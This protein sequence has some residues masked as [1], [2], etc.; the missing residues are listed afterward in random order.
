MTRAEIK[1]HVRQSLEGM[2]ERQ[3]Q[4]VL[5]HEPLLENMREY[6][7]LYREIGKQSNA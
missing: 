1:A 4:R 2:A 5:T 7:R 3:R 6:A